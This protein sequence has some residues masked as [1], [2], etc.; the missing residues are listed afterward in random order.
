MKIKTFIESV[1]ILLILALICT[2]TVMVLAEP[3]YNFEE[4]IYKVKSGDCLWD[5]A[6]EYCP[7]SMD[8]WDYINLVM[9]RNNLSESVIHA[10]QRLI[11]YQCAEG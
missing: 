5:I 2:L 7:N 3:D 4:T 8:K 9:E 11:V 10:G 6:D 1:C